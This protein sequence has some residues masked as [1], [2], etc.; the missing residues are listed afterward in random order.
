MKFHI[1]L[2]LSY[3]FTHIFFYYVF[4][5]FFT[6]IFSKN[7]IWNHWYPKFFAGFHR[8]PAVIFI[9]EW[10]KWVAIFLGDCIYKRIIERSRRKFECLFYLLALILKKPKRH[11]RFAYYYVTRVVSVFVSL[12]RLSKKPRV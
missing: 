2:Y 8:S 7:L 9:T 10:L 3:N 1:N 12:K 5:N 11:I 4:L 6:D